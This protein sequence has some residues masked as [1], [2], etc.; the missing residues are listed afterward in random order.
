MRI[1]VHIQNLK[2][3]GCEK[4]I[5]NRLSN[6]KNISDVEVNSKDCTVA[7]DYHTNNDFEAAKHLLSRIG[8]PIV[9]KENKLTTKAQSY[10]SCAIGRIKK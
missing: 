2:C 4:T 8:Y 3:S 10:L 6:V 5:V 9:G 7:F 1:T